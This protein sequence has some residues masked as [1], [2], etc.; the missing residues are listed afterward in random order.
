MSDEHFRRLERMYVG[1]P[2]NQF[3]LPTIRVSDK[4]A[5]V[6]VTVRKD[7]HHAAHAAHGSV[8]F[9]MLDDAA[10]FAANSVVEDVFVLTVNFNIVLLRPVADG[11][12]TAT[13]RLVHQSRNLL[14]AESELADSRGKTLARGGGTFMRSAIPL[15]ADV[16]Y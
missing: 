10:F 4:Q 8:H 2:I 9:K 12:I 13:G 14:V 11:V 1:A 16:G 7:F 6:T 5:Q 15:N 3:Y